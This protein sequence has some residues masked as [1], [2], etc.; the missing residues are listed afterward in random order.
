M[1]TFDTTNGC[2][3]IATDEEMERIAAWVRR[4]HAATIVV[5][6]GRS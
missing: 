3:G 2:V 1:N 6:D 4:T 5:S